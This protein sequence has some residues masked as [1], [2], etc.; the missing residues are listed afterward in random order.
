MVQG[1]PRVFPSKKWREWIRD[2]EVKFETIPPFHPVGIPVNCCAIFFRERNAGDAVGYYQGLADFL[3]VCLSC[4]KKPKSCRCDTGIRIME[5]DRFIV[6]WDGSRMRKD[7]ENPRVEIA[8][9][10]SVE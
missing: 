6:S 9:T 10:R 5:D 7:K 2:A 4:R 3:E 1:R 8:L